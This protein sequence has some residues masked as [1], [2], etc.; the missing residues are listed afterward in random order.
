MPS[1]ALAAKGLSK[2]KFD[3]AVGHVKAK[4]G[5]NPYAIATATFNRSMGVKRKVKPRSLG[6]RRGR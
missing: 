3:R 1:K 4:D 6:G 5:G 2:E